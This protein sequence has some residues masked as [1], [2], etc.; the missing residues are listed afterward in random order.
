MPHSS[1]KVK[2][3]NI[4]SLIDLKRIDRYLKYSSQYSLYESNLIASLKNSKN[5]LEA[6]KCLSQMWRELRFCDLIIVSNGREHLAHRV[7]LSLYSEQFRYTIYPIV[8]IDLGSFYMMS[9]IQLVKLNP[10]RFGPLATM[11]SRAQKNLT[12]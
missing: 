6:L 5:E 7:V 1:R 4:S 3:L 10:R 12:F 11:S 2:Y 8:L 9:Q